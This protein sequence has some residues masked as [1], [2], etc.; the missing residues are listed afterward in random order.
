MLEVKE[1]KEAYLMNLL[2]EIKESHAVKKKNKPII[3]TKLTSADKIKFACDYYDTFGIVSLL[4]V[5]EQT[6]DET[7]KRTIIE[8]MI[9][10]GL[11][12]P[13]PSTIN[14]YQKKI[15]NNFVNDFKSK[16]TNFDNTKREYNHQNWLEIF[17]ENALFTET[18]TIHPTYHI[19]MDQNSNPVRFDK[20]RAT[21]VKLAVMDAG[22]VPA[23]CIVESAYPYDA[24]NEFPKY[25]EYV[26]S[27]RG[28]K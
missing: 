6:T 26:K 9:R 12:K 19:F 27:L 7:L 20:D 8:F 28:G 18:K 25:V 10:N 11:L 3:R 17:D 2:K 21:K 14:E 24:K 15:D 16:L 23:R 5:L 22:L 4:T 13:Y 1:E